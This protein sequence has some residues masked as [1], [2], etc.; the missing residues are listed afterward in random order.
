VIEFNVLG[1]GVWI[2]VEVNQ[3]INECF[4][5]LVQ[6]VRNGLDTGEWIIVDYMLHATADN[7]IQLKYRKLG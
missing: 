7:V 3:P 6:K 1:E 4:A 5:E 2:T